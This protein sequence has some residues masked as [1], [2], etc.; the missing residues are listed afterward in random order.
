MSLCQS[1]DTL[2]MAYLDDELVSEERRE[3]ELHL[4]DCQSC[5]AHVDGERADLQL[6]RK[7]LVAPPAPDLLKARIGRA[8]D[9][10]DKAQVRETRRRFSSWILPGGAMFAAA[11]AILMFVFVRPPAQSNTGGA[12]ANEAVAQQSRGMPLEVQGASTGPWLREHFRPV[13][14]PVFYEPGIQLMGGR[15]TSVAGHEAALLQYLVTIGQNQFTL[16]AVMIAGLEPGALGGGQAIKVGDRT[17][18]VYDANGVPAITYVD[19]QR[20]MGYTFAA[21]RLS[22]QELLELVVS[23]DLIGR[24]TQ[25]VQ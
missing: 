4:L 5:R 22:P 21:E 20:G 12:V 13:E 7:A 15:L 24:T 3:L 10:E 6:V 1:I 8:L 9:L 18:H 16:T 19:A 11:A 14:P 23:S 2:A 17:L 25:E